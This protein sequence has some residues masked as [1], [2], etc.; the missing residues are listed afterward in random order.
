MYIDALLKNLPRSGGAKCAFR[1]ANVSLLRS[2]EVRP[3]IVVYKHL[4]PLGP[5]TDAL[6]YLGFVTTLLKF[7][8]SWRSRC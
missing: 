8:S 2:E 4:V 1:L 6:K 5:K 3:V 7:R